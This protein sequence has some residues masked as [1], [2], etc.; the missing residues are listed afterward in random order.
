MNRIHSVEAHNFIIDLISFDSTNLAERFSNLFDLKN[1][2]TLVWSFNDERDVS[3]MLKTPI[4]FIFDSEF[5]G[6][7]FAELIYIYKYEVELMFKKKTFSKHITTYHSFDKIGASPTIGFGSMKFSNNPTYP[8]ICENAVFFSHNSTK[9]YIS[10]K[11]WK[12]IRYLISPVNLQIY[13]NLLS[14]RYCKNYN[15]ITSWL[16]RY[17]FP[18]D[19]IKIVIQYYLPN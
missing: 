3:N 8:Q 14:N 10:D 16:N 2:E 7:K 6:G 9:F 1:T 15:E 5:A 12:V 13:K 11:K 4:K 17:N 19:L 18:N